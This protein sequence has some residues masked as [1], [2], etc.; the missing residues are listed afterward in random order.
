[1]LTLSGTVVSCNQLFGPHV[2]VRL[3]GDRE[4]EPEVGLSLE[5]PEIEMSLPPIQTRRAKGADRSMLNLEIRM[6]RIILFSCFGAAA[7]TREEYL[8]ERLPMDPSTRSVF[9][10]LHVLVLF[11]IC[12]DVFHLLRDDQKRNFFPRAAQSRGRPF[13]KHRAPC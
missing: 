4:A 1:M 7:E 6:T 11:A 10:G 8:L 2:F 13:L 12:L 5:V 9:A 3:E